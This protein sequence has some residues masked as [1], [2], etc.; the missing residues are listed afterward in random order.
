MNEYL[1]GD[2]SGDES[3]AAASAEVASDDADAAA[4]EAELELQ[5]ALAAQ[6]EDDL[7][8]Y[9]EIA[10]LLAGALISG[11]GQ[12]AAAA[13]AKFEATGSQPVF[14]GPLKA[15]LPEAEEAPVEEQEQEQ[16]QAGLA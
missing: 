12:A 4:A 10:A 6:S 8:D 9:E 11:S 16:E 15:A 1:A 14:G 3:A 7:P 13:I 2:L 5:E